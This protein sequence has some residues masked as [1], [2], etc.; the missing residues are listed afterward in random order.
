[1]IFINSVLLILL[2]V[3]L[4]IAVILLF[5][6]VMSGF[7]AKVPFVPIPNSIMKEVNKAL[8]IKD[9]SVV[10]DLGCG[11]ARVLIQ[12]SMMSPNARYI[13]LENSLFP[14]IVAYAES[15]F[16]KLKTKRKIELYKK[17]FFKHDV[18]D[19]THVFVYLFPEVMDK[20]LP[21]FEKELKSGTRLVSVTFKFTNKEPVREID[22][23]RNKYQLARKMYVYE[24]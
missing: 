14:F 1:M 20:L 8:D 23:L 13:G 17:D 3:F 15:W 18:S 2:F 10:Y 6:W 16:Y 9:G 24:F 19:A 22:L 4:V 7:F 21:K 12:N 5:I 11:D